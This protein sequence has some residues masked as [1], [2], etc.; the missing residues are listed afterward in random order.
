MKIFYSKLTLV[1]CVFSLNL[2][3]NCH[4]ALVSGDHP[5]FGEDSVTFDT[6]TGL[7]W[8]D[9]PFS[10]DRSYNDISSEF[11]PGGDFEGFRYA[12]SGEVISLWLNAGIPVIPGNDPS[13]VVPISGLIDLIGA[14]FDNGSFREV[15]ASTADPGFLSNSRLVH[16]IAHNSSTFGSV[17]INASCLGKKRLLAWCSCEA[18]ILAADERV[19]ARLNPL[20]KM[21]KGDVR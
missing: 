12:T 16:A 11:G 10:A 2:V 15:A 18:D 4:A 20:L 19:L 9:I 13:N 17:I 6:S 8:L 14:T 21:P 3:C 7:T 1:A 5:L